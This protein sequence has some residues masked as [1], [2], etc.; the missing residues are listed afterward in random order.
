MIFHAEVN[1]GGLTP[2]Q[3]AVL[4]T[5]AQH[6]GVNQTGPV[7]RTGIDRTTVGEMVRR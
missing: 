4:V 3:L 6:R 5:V 1:L 7:D 2:R